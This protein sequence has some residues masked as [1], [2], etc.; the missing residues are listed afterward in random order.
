MSR[1][2]I[3]IFSALLWTG[4]AVVPLGAQQSEQAV[5]VDVTTAVGDAFA[6]TQWAPGTV[7]SRQDARISTEQSGR[8]TW[9]AQAG[10]HV[11]QGDV[12]AKIDDE[13]LQ[14]ELMDNAARVEQLIARLDY[15]NN[16]HARL[17]RLAAN[18]NASSTQLDEAKS[19]MK[20]TE[21]DLAQARVA[22][23]QINRRI[24]LSTVSAPFAGQVVERLAQVGEYAN[25]G[26]PLLRLVDMKNR[27]IR[28]R[29]PLSVAEYVQQG[30]EVLVA[31]SRFEAPAEI[32]TVILV[33]DERSRMFEL[34]LVADDERWMIGSAVRVA[35]PLSEPREMVAIPRDAVVMRG[36]ETYVYVID[37]DNTARRVDIQTGIG[38]GSRVEVIG[39]VN[40]GDQLIIRGAERLQPGQSVEVRRVEVNAG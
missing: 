26:T 20:I 40:A 33:G 36:R 10:D 37:Q 38:L 24:N 1:M 32:S 14:L 28:V 19:Q 27:E 25:T 7:I 31:H 5:P 12:L 3:L 39:G 23:E 15:L 6:A 21:Q 4:S 22:R 35:L 17:K 18:N 11:S 8:I 16:Q 34:R 13:A 29:A 9:I 2:S 30:M